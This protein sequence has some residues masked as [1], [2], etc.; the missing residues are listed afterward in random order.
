MSDTLFHVPVQSTETDERFTPRWIFDALGETF[1]LDP[2]SPVGL[3][4]FVPAAKR[5]TREDDGLSQP[6]SGFVW[7]NPPFSTATPWADKFIVNGYG[8]WLAP[9]ANSA[10]FQR[11]MRASTAIWMMRDFPF[12][13]PTHSGKRSSMPLAMV[14]IGVRAA[15]A[16][17]RAASLHPDAGVVVRICPSVRPEGEK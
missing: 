1:D 2:A 15:T 17:A 4:T 12:V 8:L 11:M 9:V 5:Y 13:H 6:W 14:A 3:D 10:W 7:C 16:L